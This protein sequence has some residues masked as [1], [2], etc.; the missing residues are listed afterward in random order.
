ML[1]FCSLPPPTSPARRQERGPCPRRRRGDNPEQAPRSLPR[2]GNFPGLPPLTCSPFPPAPAP[3]CAAPRAV[4]GQTGLN[5]TPPSP[6]GNPPGN[7]PNQ[8]PGAPCS[9]DC[10]C[11]RTPEVSG[12]TRS[13]PRSPC[14]RFHKGQSQAGWETKTSPLKA[15][16]GGRGAREGARGSV[17]SLPAAGRWGARRCKAGKP[18]I[19]ELPPPP[20]RALRT[21]RRAR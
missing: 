1:Y 13:Q 5:S 3:S 20:R 15:P 4:S 2:G 16:R 10:P 14:S 19:L 7:N 12:E 21:W 11:G 17:W 6:G 8:C 18:R 9:P